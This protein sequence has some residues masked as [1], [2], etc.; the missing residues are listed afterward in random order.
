MI[1]KDTICFGCM[2]PIANPNEPC[3]N[4][5]YDRKKQQQKEKSY[6][7]KPGTT[8]GETYLLGRVLGI[9]SFG[10]TYLAKQEQTN[11]I[12]AIKEYY[13]SGIAMRDVDASAGNTVSYND[14][15]A[16]EIG[17]QN[18][19][20]EAK[21]LL[22]LPKME[23]IANVREYFVEN[24]TAYIV[25]DYVSGVSL[26]TYVKR[27][28]NK[29]GHPLTQKQ[30]LKIM[31]P[32]LSALSNVHKR[33]VLHRD[34]N[35]TNLIINRMGKVTLIGFS[36][37]K[38][39]TAVQMNRLEEVIQDG[40]APLEQYDSS[41]KR[42]EWTD[43][44]ALCATMYELVSGILPESAISRVKQDDVLPLKKLSKANKAIAISDCFSDAIQKGM[45]IKAQD[46][47]ESMDDFGKTLYSKEN[48]DKNKLQKEEVI[49]TKET[50]QEREMDAKTAR[51]LEEEKKRRAYM[52]EKEQRKLREEEIK[53]EQQKIQRQK[54]EKEKRY[55]EQQRRK[56]QQEEAERK[57]KREQEE[58]ERL[59]K[60]RRQK[61]EK[62]RLEKLQEEEQKKQKLQATYEQEAVEKTGQIKQKEEMTKKQQTKKNS[63]QRTAEFSKSGRK[64]L[65]YNP[66]EQ[67][68]VD[69]RV[70]RRRKML[71]VFGF[72][73]L[74]V[75]AG[76]IFV[77]YRNSE[78]MYV[79]MGTYPQSE[80]TGSAITK[81]I[82]EADYNEQK[83]ATVEGTRYRRAGDYYY[84]F[85]NIRWRVLEERDGKVLLVSEKILDAIT[86]SPENEV[87]TSWKDSYIRTWL[88]EYFYN[89]AFT[90]EEKNA[91]L[92]S[93]IETDGTETQDKIFLLSTED[94][95]DRSLYFSS[96]SERI[97]KQTIYAVRRGA[98]TGD[99]TA[100]RWWLRTPGTRENTVQ[101]VR[102]NGSLAE[103][104]YTVMSNDCGVRPA[105][106]VNATYLDK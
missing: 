74:F 8:V 52:L 62:Q 73:S 100:G 3:P 30:V 103:N 12:V 69:K 7:L 78:A 50:E 35:P 104:S 33:G 54:I 24:E 60:L 57:R 99:E 97:A 53:K 66:Y 22:S 82:K 19:E 101:V 10:V 44:Y 20:K 9:G 29:M 45:S 83:F 75:C 76:I 42:G 87:I 5:K 15:Q 27:Y 102:A 68:G 11:E 58:K 36:N 1:Q 13:P 6:C 92:E 77:L 96:D 86:F 56:K 80:I 46:R 98:Q 79:S 17:L 21:Q 28:S 26:K 84:M 72:L 90:D 2:Q 16:Y 47:Y 85:D 61:E 41:E 23:G 18:F 89:L 38:M 64:D 31:N 70:S 39:E 48:W 25:M 14:S 37:A 49:T 81:E 67:E 105:M 63:T 95:T 32:V 106:W 65:W 91:I 71:L 43:L 51:F 4:C 94:V 40:Y 59:E 88:N 93:T 34:V 55:L